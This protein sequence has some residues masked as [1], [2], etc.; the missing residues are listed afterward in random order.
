MSTSSNEGGEPR[1]RKRD[2][3][4]AM[5]GM[6]NKDA[7]K[8][9]LSQVLGEMRE[10]DD[11]FK[12]LE[13]RVQNLEIALELDGSKDW[14]ESLAEAESLIGRSTDEGPLVLREDEVCLIPGE[15][16]VRVEDAPNNSRRIF[17]A[18]DIYASVE[19]VWGIL[20]DYDNL[21]KYIPSLVK[22]EVLKRESDGVR[23]KQVGAAELLPGL[24]FKAR[25]TLDVKEWPDGISASILE[26]STGDKSIEDADD[27][28]I[29]ST[30]GIPL[31]RGVFPRPYAISHLPHRDLTMQSVE[32]G[33]FG[34]G[35]DF[36]L[37][38]GVWRM[39][40]LPGCGD[41]ENGASRLSYAVELR[42]S[43][44]VPVAL[45]E[46]R[47]ASDLVANLKAIREVAQARVVEKSSP[48]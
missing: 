15:T 16:M 3:L 34:L 28:T 2:K 14:T 18:I 12:S 31:V 47:I 48:E 26:G 23:L 33:R 5:L 10:M 40:P 20:T 45:L 25:C 17:C 44:P 29:A 8:N 42:P 7:L 38:Q 30:A 24:S 11:K 32:S 37:Y 21:Q 39:Q 19:D 22:N 13:E 36:S 41:T 27:A 43:L 6:E 46:G 9:E 35:G 1:L 4:R